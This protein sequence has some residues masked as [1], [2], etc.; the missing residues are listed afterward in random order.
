MGVV[1]AAT[2]NAALDRD[3]IALGESATLF[4]TFTGGS[5]QNVPT[6]PEIPNLHFAYLGT[7]SQST[8]AN[9]QVSS[10][11]TYNFTLTPKQA[12]DFTIP[13]LAAQVGGET[14]STQPLTLKV[15]KPSAPSPE[16][17]N[18]GSEMAFLKLE[19]PKKEIYLGEVITAKLDLYIRKVCRILKISKLP[20]FPPRVSMSASW[21]RPTAVG[22]RWVA[23]IIQRSRWA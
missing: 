17:V 4:F 13:A 6:P 21:F 14:L 16:A 22:P 1:R 20:P 8:I 2:F 15:L 7:S 18:S 9:G 5:P 19:L 23:L 11:V 12:G 10:I 3:T